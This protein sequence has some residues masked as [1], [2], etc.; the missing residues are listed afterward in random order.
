MCYNRTPTSVENIYVNILNGLLM[1]PFFAIF[2]FEGCLVGISKLRKDWKHSDY[3]KIQNGVMVRST[4]RKMGIFYE[5]FRQISVT[6]AF[7]EHHLT[8]FC[9]MLPS[10][11]IPPVGRYLELWL[12][13]IA[14]SRT[15]YS[16]FE[17]EC[18]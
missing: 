3:V 9:Q 6:P 11:F 10:S 14:Y 18:R 8:Q 5:F 16:V 4:R 2:D 17:E 13:R 7:N 15:T 1:L 12:F